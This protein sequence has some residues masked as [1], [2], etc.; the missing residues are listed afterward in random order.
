MTLLNLVQRVLHVTPHPPVTHADVVPKSEDR[1]SAKE[2]ELR[3][4]QVEFL[5][6]YN[7]SVFIRKSLANDVLTIVAG[8]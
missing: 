2:A 7:R 3:K 8:D 4:Q 1:D 6:E 5:T